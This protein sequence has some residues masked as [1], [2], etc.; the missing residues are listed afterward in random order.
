MADIKVNNYFTKISFPFTKTLVLTKYALRPSFRAAAT[1]DRSWL[2]FSLST[3]V[4]SS[5]NLNLF[6]FKKLLFFALLHSRSLTFLYL[7]FCLTSSSLP[8]RW[9]TSISV[10]IL[11]KF[12]IHKSQIIQKKPSYIQFCN[13]NLK[14]YFETLPIWDHQIRSW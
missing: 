12:Y 13:T 2:L 14:I 1:P 10:I 5:A 9:T 8:T 3:A 11:A 4:R 7:Y 6:S